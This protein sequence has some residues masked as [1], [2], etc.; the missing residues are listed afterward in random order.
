MN[1]NQ[2]SANNDFD[3]GQMFKDCRE[4]LKSLLDKMPFFVRI[5]V[6]S[7]LIFFIINLFTPYVAFYLADIPYYT[8]FFFQIWR[9]FTTAFITTGLLS[10]IFSIFF[11]YRDAVKK[12]QDLGTVKYILHFFMMTFFI[13]ILYCLMMSIVAL[14][15][16]NTI[17]LKMKISMG[18]VN[19]EGLWPI[20]MCDLTLLCLS[21]PEQDMRFFFFPCNIKAKFYPIIL[22]AFFVVLSGF[23]I[24]F[25]ILCG[26]AF[27]FLYHYYLKNKLEISNTFALRVE[28][29]FLCRWMA[30]KKGFISIAHS[31]STEIPINIEN[32][33]NINADTNRN[34]PTFK[35]KGFTVGSS[36]GNTTRENV[37]YAHLYS[38]NNEM[39]HLEDKDDES[40]IDINS[41][42]TTQV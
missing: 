28:N 31:G 3:P 36:N 9:L 6:F 25:E 13:Q 39:R 24:D 14:I 8:L 12:E 26:I 2:N 34:I 29:S 15:I 19:N 42:E 17:T 21:H 38:R 22:F 27:G 23:Q 20:L 37:D 35:G 5:I 30:N 4:G 16:Q 41:N 10:V 7:T 32:V 33:A 40:P 1:S 18:G 11:W